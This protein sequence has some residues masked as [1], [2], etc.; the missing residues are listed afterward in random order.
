MVNCLAY[1][2]TFSIG[3]LDDI[4]EERRVLYVALTRAKDELIITRRNRITSTTQS[5]K[6]LNKQATCQGILEIQ[7]SIQEPTNQTNANT[8]QL[9]ESY[10]LNELPN[11]LVEENVHT[12]NKPKI[13]EY[14]GSLGNE[15]KFGID[16]S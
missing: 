11:E 15:I 3:N 5:H 16:L 7:E 8:E 14:A 1:P 12:K 4:E 2:S 9:I 10:F 13:V 6:K